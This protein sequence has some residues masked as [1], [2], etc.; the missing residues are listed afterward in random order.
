MCVAQILAQD[1]MLARHIAETGCDFTL[2]CF[3]PSISISF[4]RDEH[5]LRITT[6]FCFC[7][8]NV[9]F[10]SNDDNQIIERLK[11]QVI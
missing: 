6:N 4:R 10:E 1:E 9:Q 2:F 8:R 7:F 3:F 11:V 5:F